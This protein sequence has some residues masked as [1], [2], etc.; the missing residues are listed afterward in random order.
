LLG[1]RDYRDLP[2]Y[3]ARF[4]AA[5]LPFRINPMTRSINPIKLREYL[6]AGLPVVSTPL[7]EVIRWLEPL[8]TPT[9]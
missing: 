1:R 5:L 2:A 9:P 4:D 3:C 6:A 8:S 7:P